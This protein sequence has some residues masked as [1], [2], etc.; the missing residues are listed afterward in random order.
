[1]P[2]TATIDIASE[3]DVRSAALRADAGEPPQAVAD[4]DTPENDTEASPDN[5]QPADKGREDAESDTG[6]TDTRSAATEKP[7]AKPKADKPAKPESDYTKK[8]KEK[9]R[10]ETNWKKFQDEKEAHRQQ[11][12]KFEQE[13]A[14]Y[15][16]QRTQTQQPAAPAEPQ[17]PSAEAYEAAAKQYEDE[18]NTAMAQ[19]AREKASEA[20]AKA[21]QQRPAAAKAAGDHTQDPQWKGEWNKNVAELVQAHPTLN[22][23]A[24][25]V[26]KQTMDYIRHPHYGRFFK[27]HPD[28]IKVAHEV[29][30]LTARAGK[31]DAL[32][33]ELTKAKAEIDRLTKLTGLRGAPPPSGA[34]GPGKGIGELSGDAAEDFVRQQ[35][36][37]ADRGE[38]N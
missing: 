26:G 8:Q 17:G 27:A 20:R 33:G 35:A 21:Q 37:K 13:R 28:G 34:P 11:V 7:E 10:Y 2:D 16:K 22:D 4:T 12:A 1:M 6:E 5:G 32:Q 24:D 14:E 36:M 9:A 18:G 29:A 25:P 15:Q 3:D 31:A 23:P 19:M 30:L 38:S